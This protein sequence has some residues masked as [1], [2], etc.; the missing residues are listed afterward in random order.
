MITKKLPS[1]QKVLKLF[2]F[3]HLLVLQRRCHLQNEAAVPPKEF[4]RV[5]FMIIAAG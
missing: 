4:L 1:P 3:R 5:H 2:S